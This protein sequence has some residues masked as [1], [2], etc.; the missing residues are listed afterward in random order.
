MAFE[1]ATGEVLLA[2]SRFLDKREAKRIPTSARIILN[3]R[4]VSSEIPTGE[5]ESFHKHFRGIDI[6]RATGV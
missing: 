6:G 4:F 5:S 3:G 2:C 1:Q